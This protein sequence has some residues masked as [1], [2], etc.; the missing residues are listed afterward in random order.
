M[1]C[2][3]KCYLKR[4]KIAQKKDG[5]GPFKISFYQSN[6]SNTTWEDKKIPPVIDVF[7]DFGNET[8]FDVLNLEE[9]L[10]IPNRVDSTHNWNIC[11][12]DF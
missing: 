6:W 1:F 4:P 10:Q 5:N 12:L 8:G 7:V 3:E 9:L 11:S 2:N